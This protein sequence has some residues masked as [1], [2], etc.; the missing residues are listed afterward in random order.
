MR[1]WR[2]ACHLAEISPLALVR[3]TAGPFPAGTSLSTYADLR[4]DLL[5]SL[6]PATAAPHLVGDVGPSPVS[7]AAA[8]DESHP[9]PDLGGLVFLN[10]AAFVPGSLSARLP[11]WR[12]VLAD[13]ADGT[14]LVR[15][16]SEGVSFEEFQTPFRGT[17][18]QRFYDSASPPPRVFHNHPAATS[19]EFIGFVR[20]EVAKG[21]ANGGM[22]CLGRV[23]EV[24]PPRVVCPLNVE[25]KKPRLICDARFSNLWQSAPRFAFD[26]LLDLTRAAR[27]GDLLTVWDHKSGYFHVRL[28]PDTQQY[29]GFEFE[30]FYYV[31]TVL[32]FGWSA[33]PFVYQT[34]SRA[35]CTYLRSLGLAEF[36]YLDDSASLAA[37]SRAIRYAFAKGVLLTALGYFVELKKSHIIPAPVQRWLGFVIDL[38]GRVFRVPEDKLAAFITL[39]EALIA[40]PAAASVASL[41]SFTGKCVSL[42]PAVP[43]ALLYTRGLFDILA[44]A[45]AQGDASVPLT[46]AALG[47]LALWAGLRAWHGT[48]RWR[49]ERHVKIPMG[50]DASNPR[51]S[52]WFVPPGRA[53]DDPVKCGDVFP[54]EEWAFDITT[55]EMLAGV[56]TLAC[57][58]PSVR[59]CIVVLE[60]DNQ[61]MVALLVTGKAAKGSHLLAAQRELFRLTLDRNIVVDA[62]WLCSADNVLADH[63]SRLPVT[64]EGRLRRD[65]FLAVQA[66]WGGFTLDAMAGAPN[67]QCRRYVSRFATPA[68]L[69]ADIFAYPLGDE[70]WVYAFPPSSVV[71]ALLAFFRESRAAG[72]VIVPADSAAPWWPQLARQAELDSL[73]LARAGDASAVIYPNGRGAVLSHDLLAVVVDYS[74]RRGRR[75][76]HDPAFR[77]PLGPGR[78]RGRGS[79]VG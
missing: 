71:G 7:I 29:F 56:R 32:P 25:P 39:A 42:A 45:D 31:Y 23:G 40:S 50:T 53:A 74:S 24:P 67:A 64:G 8:L 57:L 10:P 33:S 62:S 61:A 37:A 21:V 4:P 52:G 73:V 43:G 49:D 70:A 69:A 13:A 16:L 46:P 48:R 11:L 28:H 68:A 63:L 1:P 51:W 41:R 60:G 20:G 35:V 14:R 75:V 44:A 2:S 22:R 15:W 34:L 9:V 38:P 55:K 58:P 72:V 26:K 12:E 17:F 77:H 36:A 27:D 5:P 66:L 19:P 3:G 47:E 78:G 79:L 59:D 18:A 65:L 54:P 76:W 30:G 6:R